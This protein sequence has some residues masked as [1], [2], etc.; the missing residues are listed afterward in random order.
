MLPVC[1][2]IGLILLSADYRIVGMNNYAQGV[3]GST[4]DE[5]GKDVFNYHPKKSHKKI[6]AILKK[7]EVL[8]Q[9]SPVAMI[10]DVLNKVLMINV[11]KIKMI[12]SETPMY[13]MTFIDV[14]NETEAEFNPESG[15]M[16]LRR[17][18]VCEKNSF[19]FIDVDDILYV[20]SDGN[21]CRLYT[22]NRAYYIHSTLKEILK[23]YG[24]N[25]LFRVHKSY[26]VNLKNIHRIQYN[27]ANH[28]TIIFKGNIPPIPVARRRLSDLKKALLLQRKP[29]TKAN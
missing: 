6:E 27:S 17:L 4:I 25:S 23:R 14:T 21:Y 11:S 9:D 28:Y 2:N 22:K 18:P 13:A 20:Q 7:A 3:F 12:N 24:S 10:I 5:M 19:L 29:V 15:M 8:E 26:I 1:V 16:E